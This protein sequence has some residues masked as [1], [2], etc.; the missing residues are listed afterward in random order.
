MKYFMFVLVVLALVGCASKEFDQKSYDRQ[1]KA[2][3]KA[4]NSL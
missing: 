4:Q 2:A 3:A 1:N